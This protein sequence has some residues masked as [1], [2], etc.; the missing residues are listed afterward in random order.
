M[1]KKVTFVI[2]GLMIFIIGCVILLNIPSEYSIIRKFISV[3]SVILFG[4]F[5]VTVVFVSFIKSIYIIKN[6]F[7]RILLPFIFSWGSFV[8]FLLL[9][10]TFVAEILSLILAFIGYIFS[11][12]IPEITNKILKYFYLIFIW[13]FSRLFVIIFL[14]YSL[15]DIIKIIY[16]IIV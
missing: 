13:T 14:V 3:F 9:N 15:I 11:G 2:I 1:R 4:W 16:R 12:M 7:L 5:F 8:L 6:I 10:R